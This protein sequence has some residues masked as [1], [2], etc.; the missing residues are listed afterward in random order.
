[1]RIFKVVGMN[2]DKRDEILGISVISK[3]AFDK[4]FIEDKKV[5]GYVV[6]KE[7]KDK[8]GNLILPPHEILGELEVSC[9]SVNVYEGN[10]QSFL[11]YV[12]VENEEFLKVVNSIK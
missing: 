8:N 10:P 5:I 2:T 3:K 12:E 6:N 7:K 9:R 4:L 11:Y 1:M